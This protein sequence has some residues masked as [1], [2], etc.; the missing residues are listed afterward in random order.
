MLRVSRMVLILALSDEKQHK[1]L[2]LAIRN[3]RG[4]IRF[5]IVYSLR[6]HHETVLGNSILKAFYIGGQWYSPYCR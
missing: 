6:N 1:I 4:K 2:L 5:Q 3:S